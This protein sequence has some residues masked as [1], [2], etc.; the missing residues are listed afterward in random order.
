MSGFTYKDIDIG[1]QITSHDSNAATFSNYNLQ[2]TTTSYDY[3]KPLDFNLSDG[4]TSLSTQCTAAQDTIKNNVTDGPVPIGAKSVR[5][6]MRSGQGGKGGASGNAKSAA[7]NIDGANYG[8]GYGAPGGDGGWTTTSLTNAI[9]ISEVSKY[10][11]TIGT[12]GNTGNTGGSNTTND[13]NTTSGAGGPGNTGNTSS[14]TFYNDNVIDS[15]YSVNGGTGGGGGNS[16]KAHSNGFGG[17]TSSN[18]GS[19]GTQPDQT[20]T[21][22]GGNVYPDIDPGNP[23][24]FVQ[25]VWLYD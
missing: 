13:G 16:A 18:Q 1:N 4:G 12:A 8:R 20:T 22:N 5:L 6:L 24:G 23:T 7:N 25:I 21:A 11:I 3:Q 17:S 9:S 2:H 14:I 15:N 10:A 19:Q